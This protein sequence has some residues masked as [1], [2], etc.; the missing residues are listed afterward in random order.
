VQNRLEIEGCR[1][2]GRCLPC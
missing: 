2:E 1:L